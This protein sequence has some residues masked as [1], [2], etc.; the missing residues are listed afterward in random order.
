MNSN[1]RQTSGRLAHI[2]IGVGMLLLAACE[3]EEDMSYPTF[4]TTVSI[5][6]EAD[7]LSLSDTLWIRSE[8]SAYFVDSATHEK[9]YFSDAY[10][11][12]NVLVR[13]W[14]EQNQDYPPNNYFF[15]YETPVA[16]VSHTSAA[17]MLGLIYQNSDYLYH[18]KL[19][20]V[21]KR[22]G[23]YSIDTDYFYAELNESK[24]FGGGQVYYYDMSGDYREAYLSASI[25]NTENNIELY[26]SLN[27][28]QQA[29]FRELGEANKHKYY[30]ID[31]VD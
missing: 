10:I 26:E 2:I 19:G 15:V 28:E 21:F 17:T 20:V 25:G 6:H 14:M 22:P 7:T 24:A 23:I 13:A 27:K 30:F 29:S 5:E 3:K 9:H 12:M 8:L 11:R 18:F 4:L 31:V 1:N 16:Y